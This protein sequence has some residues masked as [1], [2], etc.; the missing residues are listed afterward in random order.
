MLIHSSVS[1]KVSAKT[2]EVIDIVK[3]GNVKDTALETLKNGKWANTAR[4][5][6]LFV[7]KIAADQ[8]PLAIDRFQ[9]YFMMLID[10]SVSFKVIA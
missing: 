7:S 6:V 4:V 5:H 2:R 1:F 8:C 10:S 9:K 3:P